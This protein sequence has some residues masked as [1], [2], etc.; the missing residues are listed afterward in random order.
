MALT[1]TE[2]SD[3]QRVLDSIP[4]CKDGE[5]DKEKT[6]RFDRHTDDLC[7]CVHYLLEA[8][9]ELSN[10]KSEFS[11]KCRLDDFE[12]WARKFQLYMNHAICELGDL[13]AQYAF[14]KGLSNAK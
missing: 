6:A 4:P 13:G 10:L 8:S 5:T 7:W 2:K 1:E 14:K 11:L 3:W 9:S 12:E